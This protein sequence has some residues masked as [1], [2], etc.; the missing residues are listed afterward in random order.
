MPL[1][2]IRAVAKRHDADVTFTLKAV[3]EDYWKT[4][5]VTEKERRAAMQA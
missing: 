1:E 3:A 4:R 2:E 5:A